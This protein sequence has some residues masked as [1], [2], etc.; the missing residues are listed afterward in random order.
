M[1]K[2]RAALFRS[3]IR[4][5]LYLV[6]SVVVVST[7]YAT[8]EQIKV[9]VSRELQQVLKTLDTNQEI[10]LNLTDSNSNR[11]TCAYT[12]T[13]SQL[14]RIAKLLGSARG[15]R[16][17]DPQ[18]PNTT[19]TTKFMQIALIQLSKLPLI[20]DSQEQKVKTAMFIGTL[21]KT[22]VLKSLLFLDT[23]QSDFLSETQLVSDKIL[24]N[25]EQLL[26]KIKSES[27]TI[28]PAQEG[29]RNLKTD[30]LRALKRLALFYYHWP[31]GSRLSSGNRLYLQYDAL[32]LKSDIGLQNKNASTETHEEESKK[33]HK[34]IS[35][36]DKQL[37]FLQE[38]VL[39]QNISLFSTQGGK[40]QLLY[41]LN[42][43]FEKQQIV[44]PIK[45]AVH[46]CTSYYNWYTWQ[47]ES[48]ISLRFHYANIGDNS[49][50][51]KIGPKLRAID[52]SMDNLT[53]T[54]DNTE[55]LQIMVANHIAEMRNVNQ[56][57][58]EILKDQT[59][60]DRE[61]KK[62]LDNQYDLTQSVIRS[63]T[64]NK[65]VTVIFG[66]EEVRA[67]IGR[68]VVAQAKYK[69]LNSE[70]LELMKSAIPA[71]REIYTTEYV[72]NASDKTLTAH[73]KVLQQIADTQYTLTSFENDHFAQVDR[74]TSSKLDSILLKL[75]K[76]AEVDPLF[77]IEVLDKV[78]KTTETIQTGSKEAG[79]Q[80]QDIDLQVAKFK[81]KLNTII[82]EE[83]LPAE[84]SKN[85]IL[86]IVQQVQKSHIPI[87]TSEPVELQKIANPQNFFE[88]HTPATEL[89]W[90]TLVT[91]KE[92]LKNE[93]KREVVLKKLS[94][95]IKLIEKQVI[96]TISKILQMGAWPMV[97][98][99]SPET[100]VKPIFN[101][102]QL[103]ALS[104]LTTVDTL[105]AKCA[106]E[107]TQIC[108]YLL[109]DSGLFN[110]SF[111]KVVAI[112]EISQTLDCIYTTNS[113]IRQLA[114]ITPV[115]FEITYSLY[116]AEFTYREIAKITMQSITASLDQYIHYGVTDA[117]TKEISDT[118]NGMPFIGPV[119][120][121]AK[122]AI[123]DNLFKLQLLV[124]Q[125]D[126]TVASVNVKVEQQQLT[127]TGMAL[128]R[129]YVETPLPT[130]SAVSDPT[131]TITDRFKPHFIKLCATVQNIL[132]YKTLKV[133]ELT[134]RQLRGYIQELCT[135][136]D[137]LASDQNTARAYQQ[138]WAL[139]K[140]S[141]DTLVNI[142]KERI[143]ALASINQVVLVAAYLLDLTS[144]MFTETIQMVEEFT[145]SKTE[146]A[147]YRKDLLST[148]PTQEVQ[149]TNTSA[150]QSQQNILNKV[151]Q[152][153]QT[154]EK[155]YLDILLQTTR[156]KRLQ[157]SL[158]GANEM[159]QD[160]R[161][162]ARELLQVR[163]IV[164]ITKRQVD[165]TLQ[166]LEQILVA[167][168]ELSDN[169]FQIKSTLLLEKI[170]QF[171]TVLWLLE[172]EKFAEEITAAKTIMQTIHDITEE[173]DTAKK[174]LKDNESTRQKLLSE[175][176]ILL[177]QYS[178]TE[179]TLTEMQKALAE[180]QTADG[181]SR[182]ND[183]L[184]VL[185]QQVVQK[186]K[187][188]ATKDSERIVLEAKL[189]D[190]TT[191]NNDIEEVIKLNTTKLN[192]ILKNNETNP[193]HML[194]EI[195]KKKKNKFLDSQPT[196]L[197]DPLKTRKAYSVTSQYSELPETMKTITSSDFEKQYNVIKDN[198]YVKP[199]LASYD[200]GGKDSGDS[201]NSGKG[202]GD[203]GNSGK[204]SSDSG[205]GS[206]N[207][208]SSKKSV[209]QGTTKNQVS[210]PVVA[211]SCG[212]ALVGT[213]IAYYY[214]SGNEI[215]SKYA[216]PVIRTSTISSVVPRNKFIILLKSMADKMRQYAPL[217]QNVIVS[218]ITQVTSYTKKAC[219]VGFRTGYK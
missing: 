138:N 195:E 179:K 20:H 33:I 143:N 183:E 208:G 112:P 103:M 60:Q 116:P 93:Q 181:S 197:N 134:G 77:Y 172:R 135:Q 219:C 45:L 164:N 158:N 142:K 61:V 49:F 205:K 202:S 72:N 120:D 160:V 50:V 27:E 210:I 200:V 106:K 159:L 150:K 216:G 126:V 7:F 76:I 139:I 35:V 95:T 111:V 47:S 53:K 2:Q 128:L 38:M 79:T 80:A 23:R 73:L 136:I 129:D 165:Q 100:T 185:Q 154:I 85:Q 196:N 1:G 19:E 87:T 34:V 36:Y 167:Y 17:T 170:A 178:Q 122:V 71:L 218:K 90:P 78:S 54:L 86:Q 207:S 133:T 82:R 39:I 102:A 52:D 21:I 11:Y 4:S 171:N 114:A 44:E 96:T 186:R 123:K 5:I 193:A 51:V 141:S 104:Q 214:F 55:K 146:L 29:G 6:F 70:L 37:K 188:L 217:L 157:A 32:V 144:Y 10:L 3:Y 174:T 25:V 211:G 206:G 203:S 12:Q 13:V 121:L 68:L 155:R 108:T 113:H 190:V 107:L 148:L 124:E 153:K 213:F 163:E 137:A 64:L 41:D 168:T 180:K 30:N 84:C 92:D 63:D 187:K 110:G 156:Y 22:I 198:P 83:G 48:A 74:D 56:I 140:K 8:L 125:F 215:S 94:A 26:E 115:L 151:D 43:S 118:K 204:G 15:I 81:T 130:I 117:F 152:V 105:N 97:E 40:L 69:T 145:N 209:K 59:E 28:I 191:K 9:S 42:S 212:L 119:Q 149:F 201:G 176:N 177:L 24:A 175:H 132:Q 184:N 161:S 199:S 101:L 192:E 99:E 31:V 162:I 194:S 98:I 18:V 67:N 91:D 169:Q 57:E 46:I 89:A 62:L 75:T 189:T 66:I 65:F 182:T 16:N 173:L 131:S 88:K 127:K 166:T 14:T 147:R 58:Q 109:K